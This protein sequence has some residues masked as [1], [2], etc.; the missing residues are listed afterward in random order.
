MVLC[1]AEFLLQCARSLSADQIDE[2][3]CGALLKPH[4]RLVLHKWT[5]DWGAAEESEEEVK[6]LANSSIQTLSMMI[7]SCYNQVQVQPEISC[8]LQIP[9]VEYIQFKT[10][11]W[12]L[13][14]TGP[15]KVQIVTLCDRRKCR[16]R[17]LSNRIQRIK[18]FSEVFSVVPLLFTWPLLAPHNLHL[19]LFL[20]HC[21]EEVNRRVTSRVD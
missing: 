13:L 6:S 14:I 3:E 1:A 17:N 20:L 4:R 15:Q 12:M 9:T 21:T 5:I 7:M 8:N 10:G 11:L 18:K 19:F 2:D 16:N